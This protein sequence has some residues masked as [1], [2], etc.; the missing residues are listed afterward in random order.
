[1]IKRSASKKV[2]N[3]TSVGLS[4]GKHVTPVVVQS[5]T[6]TLWVGTS[7]DKIVL[8]KNEIFKNKVPACFGGLK[9]YIILFMR[10]CMI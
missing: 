3:I 9:S 8:I 5:L 2:A 7:T 10:S 4:V 1:M 6:I